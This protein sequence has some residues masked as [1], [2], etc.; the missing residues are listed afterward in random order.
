MK[1]VIGVFVAGERNL[2]TLMEIAWKC[3][4]GYIVIQGVCPKE[5]IG[6]NFLKIEITIF[7][8]L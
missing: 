4:V 3:I 6:A 7:T 8:I 2:A 1:I 5:E